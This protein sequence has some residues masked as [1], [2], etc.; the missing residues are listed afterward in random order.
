[1]TDMN[2]PF[3]ADAVQAARDKDSSSLKEALRRSV[4]HTSV[5]Q[6]QH[7][8]REV[9]PLYLGPIDLLWLLKEI[10][11]KQGFADNR[12][13]MLESLAHDLT[14]AGFQPGRDFSYA[15]DDQTGRAIVMSKLVWDTVRENIS[16]RAAQ[17]YRCFVRLLRPEDGR[18]GFPED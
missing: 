9:V 3:V 17:H 11:D 13:Q 2:Q 12:D 1:M 15:P 4:E 10:T 18:T 16:D 6:T 7:L 5:K 8:F 14:T